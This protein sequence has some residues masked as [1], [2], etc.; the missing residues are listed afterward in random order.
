MNNKHSHS[1]MIGELFFKHNSRNKNHNNKSQIHE[2]PFIQKFLSFKNK[3]LS[4]KASLKTNQKSRQN[5][6]AG[7]WCVWRCTKEDS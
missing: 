1:Y 6:F 5:N 4:Q 7:R 3:S 2:D